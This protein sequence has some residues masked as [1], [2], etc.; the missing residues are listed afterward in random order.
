MKRKIQFLIIFTI[1]FSVVKANEP[2][3]KNPLL[4]K[5]NLVTAK[6]NNKPS[7]PYTLNRTMEFDSVHHFIGKSTVNGKERKYNSGKYFIA[8]DSTVICIHEMGNGK[9]APHSFTYRFQVKDQ[10]LH[11][12][13][14][15][16]RHVPTLSGVLKIMY[17]DEYWMKEEE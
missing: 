12:H 6:L 1:I 3:K 17:I 8:N 15:Y 2:V 13:G 4:G 9:L 16:Y 7:P 11:L 5:W 14:F 10:T